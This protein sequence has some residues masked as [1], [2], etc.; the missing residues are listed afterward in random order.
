MGVSR[1]F[2]DRNAEEEGRKRR[3]FGGIFGEGSGRPTGY[4]VQS[5]HSGLIFEAVTLIRT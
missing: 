4:K 3:A 2:A 5:A 1:R